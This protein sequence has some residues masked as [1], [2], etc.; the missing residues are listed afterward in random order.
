MSITLKA[1]QD[2]LNELDAVQSEPVARLERLARTPIAF[3]G[4][5]KRCDS[6]TG[7]EDL[8]CGGR[9]LGTCFDEILPHPE[10]RDQSLCSSVRLRDATIKEECTR[11]YPHALQALWKALDRAE[12][13]IQY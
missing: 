3:I 11:D 8:R 13:L 7:P 6:A 4:A 1:I 2:L 9:S 5:G 12:D 10:R